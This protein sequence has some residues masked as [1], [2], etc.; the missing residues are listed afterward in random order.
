MTGNKP[1]IEDW[2]EEEK[3]IFYLNVLKNK[4]LF[5]ILG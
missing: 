4:I 5:H 1:W 2:T 3:S